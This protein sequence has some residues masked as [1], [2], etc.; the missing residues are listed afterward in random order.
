MNGQVMIPHPS[1]VR[2]EK[3]LL[4]AMV[5]DVPGQLIFV[6]GLS[7]AGKSEIRYN[8]MRAFARAPELWAPG[9]LPAIAL[10]AAP[11]DRSNFSSKEFMTRFYLELNEPNL[12][13]LAERSSVENPDQVH[14]RAEHRLADAFWVDTR[15]RTTENQLRTYA[16]RMARERGL[17]AMFVEEAASITYTHRQKPPGDHMVNYMCLA[18]EIATTMVFFGVPRTSRL[19][20]GNAE[21]R[22]RS[23][24]VY[25]ERYRLNSATDRK[26]FERLAVSLARGYRFNRANLLRRNLDLAYATS[27]GVCGE[28]KSYLIR[29]DDLRAADGAES[30]SKVHLEGAVYTESALRTLHAEAA[31]F[32]AL[33][34]PASPSAIR[35]IFR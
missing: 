23:R 29:A 19:W 17:K 8:V 13:W 7:G 15:R 10:R 30:I 28:L 14:L 3:A 22:R 24:F 16:E 12:N 20:E 27:A 18:E 5:T 33:S 32:D 31:Q 25:V 34:T 4:R 11:T 1:F 2:G 26:N 35:R 21:V 9:K 6:I